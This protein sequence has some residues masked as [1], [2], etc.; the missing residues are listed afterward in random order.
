M[1]PCG[2]VLPVAVSLFVSS[3][4]VSRIVDAAIERGIDGDALCRAAALE[5]AIVR[6]IDGQVEI[7]PYLRLWSEVT[8]RIE[9]PGFPISI[10]RS[11][12][13]G[14]NLLRFVC[15]SS[16]NVGEALERSSRYL[17]LLTNAV[18]WPLERGEDTS[19]LAM[20]R[21]ASPMDGAHLTRAPD[22]FGCAEVV[23]LIRAFTGVDWNPRGVSF[24]FPAPAETA[25]HRELFRCP[26]RF[27]QPRT[28]IHLA[29]SALSLP[30]LGADPTVVAFFESYIEKQIGPERAPAPATATD[31]VKGVL[32]RHLRGDVPTLEAVAARLDISGRTLRRRLT[33][34]DTSFQ[35]L[36]D[37]TRFACA[38]QHL[39]EGQLS[40][41]EVAFLLGFSE[42]SAFHRAF[43]RWAGVTP[44]MYTRGARA[45][46]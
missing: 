41:A 34:E 9:D 19:V 30:L 44:Q 2:I 14:H 45:T 16:P 24:A 31:Q 17:R 23:T 13:K 6:D 27:G 39:E 42:P 4:I 11:W 46:R 1:W 21:A 20:V 12:S 10:A 29:T 38:R 35:R 37:E 8:R 3:L 28:E 25:V 15:A 5:P 32:A 33:H 26:I 7:V 36:V 43:K 22:E 18:T 40:V